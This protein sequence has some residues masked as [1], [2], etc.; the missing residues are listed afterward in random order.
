M[1]MSAGKKAYTNIDTTERPKEKGK[2]DKRGG[3][4]G[5]NRRT[6]KGHRGVNID[7]ERIV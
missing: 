4:E 7:K 2:V 6:S 5:G 3:L 1:E